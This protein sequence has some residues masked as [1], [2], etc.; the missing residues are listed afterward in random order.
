MQPIRRGQ[1]QVGLQQLPR[2][3]GTFHKNKKYVDGNTVH[4]R[5]IGNVVACMLKLHLLI[6]TL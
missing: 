2:T 5:T 3:T 4:L 6:C 1:Q